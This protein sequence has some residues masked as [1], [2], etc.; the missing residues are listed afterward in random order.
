M[1]SNRRLRR[2]IPAT[3]GNTIIQSNGFSQILVYPRY[4]GEHVK[5]GEPQMLD[6]GLSPL[7]RGTRV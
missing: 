2:F 7:P 5:I 1:H 6:A 4:R 3:A